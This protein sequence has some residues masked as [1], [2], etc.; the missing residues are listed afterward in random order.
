MKQPDESSRIALDKMIIRK[1][2]E[3]FDC[4]IFND[5]MVMGPVTIRSTG[6]A[7]RKEKD[8]FV[9]MTVY[10]MLANAFDA[11]MDEIT[12]LRAK[13]ARIQEVINEQ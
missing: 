4:G 8:E 6:K 5:V 9:S 11:A 10:E 12:R 13:L 7:S 1:F 2:L 3:G